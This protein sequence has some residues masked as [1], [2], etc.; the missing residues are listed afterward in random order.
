MRTCQEIFGLLADAGVD[1]IHVTEY[2]SC[3]LHSRTA[4]RALLSLPVKP[5]RR[6]SSSLTVGWMTVKRQKNYW[7]WA[8]ILF[9]RQGSISKS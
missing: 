1:Y 6:P 3:C 7:I 2:K 8:L 4:T 5:L 9:Y